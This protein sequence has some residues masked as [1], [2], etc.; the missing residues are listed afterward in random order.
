MSIWLEIPQEAWS[1]QTGAPTVLGFSAETFKETAY[2]FWMVPT[3][4][5]S[6]GWRYS[7]F[8]PGPL[9]L[10]SAEAAL[11]LGSSG[12]WAWSH[13]KARE[14]LTNK[15]ALTINYLLGTVLVLGSPKWTSQG[16][17]P[18]GLNPQRRSGCTWKGKQWSRTQFRCWMNEAPLELR[19]GA[20]GPWNMDA[21]RR[22]HSE[23]WI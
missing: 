15:Q 19:G 5:R 12:S 21:Q 13:L 22:V 11:A 18:L 2:G 10:A 17:C 20:R 7:A 6:R 23:G 9:L 14:H 4:A 16:W 1:L 8:S 3:E